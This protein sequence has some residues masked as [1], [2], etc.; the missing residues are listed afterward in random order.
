MM[1]NDLYQGQYWLIL[2]KWCGY[3][4]C[5]AMVQNGYFGPRMLVVVTVCDGQA[6]LVVVNI[7][8]NDAQMMVTNGSKLTKWWLVAV[9]DLGS[10]PTINAY[11][12]F[13]WLAPISNP[14]Q[15]TQQPSQ[16]TSVHQ[17]PATTLKWLAQK[18][19]LLA[20]NHPIRVVG[21]S[22]C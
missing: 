1:V 14:H 8:V 21:V 7:L 6:W 18:T 3:I 13:H 20:M 22:M 16:T 15:W 4:W 10:Q 11:W 19:V 12:E 2:P 5:L 17:W 9:N